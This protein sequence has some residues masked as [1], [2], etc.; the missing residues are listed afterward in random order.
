VCRN[1]IGQNRRDIESFPLVPLQFLA[2]WIEVCLGQV[3]QVDYVKAENRLL[4]EKLGKKRL[5][6][7]QAVGPKRAGSNRDDRIPRDDLALA[8]RAGGLEIRRQPAARA[9]ATENIG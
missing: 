7:G 2:A 5:S 4:R 9:G 3:L 1:W 6:L 8:S